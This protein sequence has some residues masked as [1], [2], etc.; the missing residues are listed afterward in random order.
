MKSNPVKTDKWHVLIKN[1]NESDLTMKE[2][3]QM[4]TINIHQLQ[5][6][7]RKFKRELTPTSFVKIINPIY[8]VQKPLSIEFHDLR[9]NIPESYN[10]SSLIDL[11]KTLRKLGD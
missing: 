4:N 11:I 7:L 1:Y 10:E 5:Y 6:W 9:I 2:F 3:C 8:Q